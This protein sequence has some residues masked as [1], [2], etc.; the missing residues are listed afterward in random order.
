MTYDFSKL[1]SQDFEELICDLLQAEWN[2]RLE[3][4]TMGRDRGID[5]RCLSGPDS[6]VIIQCK[7]R[8]AAN[9]RRLRSD[10][11]R[12]ELPKIEQLN[13]KRYLLVTSVGLTPE[14]KEQLVDSLAPFVSRS[15]DIIGR[16]EVNSLI[17]KHPDVE[18]SNF[19]LWLTSTAVMKR[20]LHNAQQCQTEFE[21][22][23]VMRRLP[24]ICSE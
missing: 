24:H 9:F 21:V 11:V 13:P 12:E 22:E 16:S 10:V 1:S 19:K 3:S 6:T 4:F 7:H 17:R 20:V 18:V 23:R 2:V 14:N 5:L 8:P 15:D